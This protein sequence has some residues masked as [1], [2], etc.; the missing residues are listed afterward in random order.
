MLRHWLLFILLSAS[1]VALFIF[2]AGIT[3]AE[4]ALGSFPL[5][6]NV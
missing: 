3:K 4:L 6:G 1:S 5:L 2:F